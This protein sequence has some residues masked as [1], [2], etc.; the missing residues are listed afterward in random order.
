MG[1]RAPPERTEDVKQGRGE[2]KARSASAERDVL[3]DHLL[4]ATLG[5]LAAELLVADDLGE[6]LIRD[7]RKRRRDRLEEAPVAQT[8]T[9]SEVVAKERQR[10]ARG[11]GARKRI[12]GGIVTP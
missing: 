1:L 3:T 9:K 8:I 4:G 7:R 5:T 10:R 2:R 12:H 11:L 6:I